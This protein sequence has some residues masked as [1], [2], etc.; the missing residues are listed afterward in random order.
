[1]VEHH[2]HTACLL[3]LD[4]RLACDMAWHGIACIAL[5]KGLTHA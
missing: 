4:K 5:E 1:M 3:A 2:S